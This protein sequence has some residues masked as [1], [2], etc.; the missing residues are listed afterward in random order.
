MTA[1]HR[2]M[3]YSVWLI[4]WL[5]AFGAY[6]QGDRILLDD[7]AYALEDT[8]NRREVLAAMQQFHTNTQVGLAIAA[9]FENSL[10]AAGARQHLTQWLPQQA[11]G[12][13]FLITLAERA[14]AFRECELQVSPAVEALLP[15][16]ERQ[17]IQT[18]LLE[19]YF[20][21][22]P[23]PTDAYTSGLLAGIA[24]MEKKILENRAKEVDTEKKELPTL[25]KITDIDEEFSAGIKDYSGNMLN[26]SYAMK[27]HELY[28]LKV[29]KF[30]VYNIRDSLVYDSEKD[31]NRV[32]IKEEGQFSWDGKMNVGV[33]DSKY[34]RYSDSPFK[35]KLMASTNALYEEVFEADTTASVDEDADKWNDFKFKDAVADK[36]V[37]S[38][39]AFKSLDSQ[40]KKSMKGLGLEKQ[41]P[42]EYLNESLVP[43]KF[44]EQGPI[45]LNIRFAYVLKLFEQSLDSD[46][47]E[48]YE[49]YL[50]GV[51]FSSKL[52]MTPLG[53]NVS[54][55]ALGFALDLDAVDNPMIV[56][57]HLYH[58]IAF[59]TGFDSFYNRRERTNA[60]IDE[61]KNA[62]STFIDRLRLDTEDKITWND[63]LDAAEKIDA[64][65]RRN[66]EQK[67]KNT[68][69]LIYPLSEIANNRPLDDI[70]GV[71]TFI[72]SITN[73]NVTEERILQD[74]NESLK[75]LDAIES[76]INTVRSVIS[77]YEKGMLREYFV[78]LEIVSLKE[79]LDLVD[80]QITR[81][82]ASIN[83]LIEYVNL[84]D[85]EQLL[86]DF[87]SYLN[88]LLEEEQEERLALDESKAGQV[89]SFYAHITGIYSEFKELDSEL[90]SYKKYLEKIKTQV[91]R[92]GLVT[93]KKLM[94]K[95]FFNLRS[96]LIKDWL[97]I[98]YS[99]WGGFYTTNHDFMHIEVI[100]GWKNRALDRLHRKELGFYKDFF[101][102]NYPTEYLKMFPE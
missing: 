72:E 64:F 83:S 81:S 82:R 84:N 66:D 63:L 47:R 6:A 20:R 99:Y 77:E 2:I 80:S 95:G 97:A 48:E 58:F 31:G 94:E 25:V 91:D 33:N 100:N 14:K 43:I 1:M 75:S 16:E 54:N 39:E 45:L 51:T 52:R 67:K 65:E 55:H 34:I 44:L 35:V 46:K 30:K 50:N 60:F 61:L 26:V 8:T 4:A 29:A 12:I 9:V 22:S 73:G 71:H 76:E 28:D 24:A 56:D 23:I 13:T 53:S 92:A 101:L 21:S 87:V 41:H 62:H 85:V 38:Y 17:Q 15:L 32:P 18:G 78:P 86:Q 19:F 88:N 89:K 102:S 10:Y 3:R 96:D 68:T 49:Q 69:P 70:A 42:L 40:Y 98:D 93:G 27:K 59:V 90:E 37:W 5:G 7:L 79:Y 74:C 11:H 36:S 57:Q